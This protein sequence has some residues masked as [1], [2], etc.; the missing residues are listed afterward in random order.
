MK[1][2]F[3]SAAFM[4]T[5][6]GAVPVLANELYD[7]DASHTQVFF[8]VERFGFNNTI[9]A[10]TDVKGTLDLDE[11]HP[12][13]STVNVQIGTDSLWSGHALR[14]K[15]V[16]GPAWLNVEKFPT[17]TFRSTKVVL[18]GEDKANVTGDLTI[19]GQ[20]RPAVLQI[21]LNKIGTDRVS[22]KKAAGFSAHTRIKRSEYG[23]KTALGFVGDDVMIKIEALA[24]HQ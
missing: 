20:T 6:L 8:S 5:T 22:K 15:H 1:P 14:E 18:D 3:F 21:A 2:I 4:L 23:H 10:F 12:E 13:N 11:E 7:L 17:M 19:W 24:I 16:K 9:G